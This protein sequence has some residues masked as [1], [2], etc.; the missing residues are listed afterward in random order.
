MF[1][2]DQKD[3]WLGDDAP[4]E[5]MTLLRLEREFGRG[6]HVWID[7]SA[8]FSDGRRQGFKNARQG[9][10]ADNQDVDIAACPRLT[11]GDRTVYERNLYRFAKLAQPAAQQ[12]RG[13]GGFRQQ[14]FQFGKHG[15][16]LIG[17][18]AHRGFVGFTQHQAEFYQCGQFS[19]N[20]AWTDRG[21]TRQLPRLKR[22][23]GMLEQQR[24]Q[25]RSALPKQRRCQG[26]REIRCSQHESKCTRYEN[27]LQ[28]V[29]EA[30]RQSALAEPRDP[31]R[32]DGI[33]E[34]KR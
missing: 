31:Q 18:E 14:R 19:M 7:L 32:I 26:L 23:V 20:R 16:R 17:F 4:N 3:L 2:P 6:I 33:T 25:R 30:L 1:V 10:G 9:S 28:E 11:R 29:E 8:Q 12:L 5:R 13:T 22:L 15:G 27:A 24:Q 21:I 34:A